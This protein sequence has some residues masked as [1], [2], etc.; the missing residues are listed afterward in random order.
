M[1]RLPAEGTEAGSVKQPDN[2]S[3]TSEQD[4][5]AARHGTAPILSIVIPAYNEAENLT[6][7]LLALDHY[8]ATKLPDSQVAVVDD[9]SS[10]AT[11]QLVEEFCLN[12]TRFA[13]IRSSHRGKAG[14]VATGMLAAEGKYAMFMDMDMATSIEHVGEFVAI[15][16]EGDADIVAA[17]REAPGAKRL[18]A[19]LMRRFL[20]KGFN[21]LV[22][23]LLLPGVT[24]TQCGF[25]AFTRPAARELF[26]SL[27]VFDDRKEVVGPRVTAF[28]VELLVAA[29]RR[30]YR[31]VQRGV[32]WRHT[33]TR[34]VH[35]VK[36]PIRMLRQLLSVWF[37]DRRRRYHRP[38]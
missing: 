16:E 24:D 22:Q 15:L 25:K 8:L 3:G 35:V 23:A 1:S 21:L 28:D 7:R 19:P 27:I 18:N 13:L 17:S 29:R 10:D 31:I 26:G 37:N 30:G 34:R 4:R 38:G 2:R 32:I 20:G 5:D 12:H 9:G 36:E 33:H 6:E 14:A 11:P